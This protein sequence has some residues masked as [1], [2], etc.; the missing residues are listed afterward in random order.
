MSRFIHPM[1]CLTLNRLQS[2]MVG[3]ETINETQ[4]LQSELEDV[5]IEQNFGEN[6]IGIVTKKTTF[7]LVIQLDKFVA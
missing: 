3:R 4:K 1:T 5:L 6:K 7:L 2:L